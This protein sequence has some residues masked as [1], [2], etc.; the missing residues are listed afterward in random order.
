[1]IFEDN[2]VLVHGV[3]PV[4]LDPANDVHEAVQGSALKQFMQEAR[5]VRLPRRRNSHLWPY[6]NNLKNILFFKR[7]IITFFDAPILSPAIFYNPI[8]F[9]GIT[10]PIANYI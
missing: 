10:S 6:N 2:G 5:L 7:T 1:M 8:F 9:A 4:T 3:L